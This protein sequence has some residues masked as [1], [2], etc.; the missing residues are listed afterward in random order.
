MWEC[1]IVTRSRG[2]NRVPKIME[3][4]GRE[5]NRD[6]N[7]TMMFRITREDLEYNLRRIKGITER[8]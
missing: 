5:E 8:F 6:R 7:S 1:R 4:K 3:E 2:E